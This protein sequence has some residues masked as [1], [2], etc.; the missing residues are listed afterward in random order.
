MKY[1]VSIIFLMFWTIIL[2][3]FKE[4]QVATHL[5]FFHGPEAAL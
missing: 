1:F 5:F 4:W 3:F 2:G